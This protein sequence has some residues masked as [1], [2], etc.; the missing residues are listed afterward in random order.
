MRAML[1]RRG[2][3]VIACASF[4]LI[5]S[6][7][8]SPNVL[9]GSAAF[10]DYHSE[11]PGMFRRITP[12]DLPKPWATKSVG[13]YPAIVSRPA[14]AWPSAPP[15]FKVEL[16]ADGLRGPRLIRTAPNGD[17]FITESGAGTIKILR[18]KSGLDKPERSSVFATGLHQPFGLAFYPPGDDPQWLYIANTDSVVRFRYR[19]GDLT[20]RAAAVI[21]VDKLPASAGHWTRDLAFSLDGTRMFISVGSRSNV[22]DPRLFPIEDRRADILEYTPEGRFV[23]IYAWGIRNP[24]GIAVNPAT[25]ELWCS[26]NERDGLGDNLVP[27]YVTHVEDGG[28]YGWPWYYIGGHPDP[29]REGEHPELKSKAIIPDVLL[30]PHLASL[31]LTFYNGTQFP[32][33]YS[34]DVFA[35]EHGS[36]NRS[37]R[38]GYEVI[39]IPLRDGRA[40]GE[41]EDFLTGFVSA[42]GH[43]WGRPVGVAVGKDGSLLITDD[44]SNS[45][46]RVSY[47]GK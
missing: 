23:K 29:R 11:R 42:D 35:A 47:V 31:E 12:A 5:A 26:V 44:A 24:A 32:R 33:E 25:G 6:D 2:R 19:N 8:T 36:W 39:R 3:S 38:A 40:S 13:N 9:T 18:G 16:Y 28:F 41:Y 22:G 4:A 14:G 7:R 46:W 21:I 37:V 17:S 10:A 45:V 15:G 27:D 1:A 43:V 30:T 20:A 34:G